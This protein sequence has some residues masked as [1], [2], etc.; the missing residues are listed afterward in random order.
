MKDHYHGFM[1]LGQE[2]FVTVDMGTSAMDGP[3]PDVREFQRAGNEPFTLYAATS[4]QRRVALVG[5]SELCG[6]PSP[7]F[8]SH[9]G[10]FDLHDAGLSEARHF[11]IQGGKIHPCLAGDT[12]T[13][14]ADI[15]PIQ[16]L[17][18]KP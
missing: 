3:A 2:G 14:G 12:V 17:N 18:P 5:P 6:T 4:P 8:L 9:H 7:G 10:D 1:S 13:E 16:V 11:E 15:D